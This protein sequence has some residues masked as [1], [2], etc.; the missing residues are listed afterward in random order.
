MDGLPQYKASPAFVGLGTKDPQ[1][2]IRG[3][4]P[5]APSGPQGSR[6]VFSEKLFD[7]T[8]RQMDQTTNY[9]SA[10]NISIGSGSAL[11]TIP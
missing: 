5:Y 3:N 10:L 1:A 9:I 4:S 6:L 7:L 2:F 8:S 11:G